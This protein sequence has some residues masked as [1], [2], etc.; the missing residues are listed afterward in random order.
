MKKMKLERPVRV[1]RVFL[2]FKTVDLLLF[3]VNVVVIL[4][5]IRQVAEVQQ[6][7]FSIFL[8]RHD[9]HYQ[10]VLMMEAKAFNFTLNSGI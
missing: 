1:S 10:I 2:I 6:E 8:R 4:N 7:V 3:H 5:F 9:V